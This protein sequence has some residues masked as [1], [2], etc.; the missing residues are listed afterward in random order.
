MGEDQLKADEY[1]QLREE[2]GADWRLITQIA[3]T[4]LATTAVI[5]AAG[6]AAHSRVLVVVAP[7]PFYLGVLYLVQSTWLQNRINT[8]IASRA[9][10]GALNYERHVLTTRDPASSAPTAPFWAISLWWWMVVAAFLGALFSAFP[11]LVSSERLSGFK[12][13]SPGLYAVGGAV[14]LVVFLKAASAM[15]KRAESDRGKWETYWTDGEGS[16]ESTSS[17]QEPSPPAR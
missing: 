9:P 6:L 1:R 13:G 3:L 2:K 11:F 4:T 12:T 10:P 15:V 7:V 14:L 17:S 5:A 16:P 8:F